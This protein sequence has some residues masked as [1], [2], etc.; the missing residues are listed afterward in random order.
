MLDIQA[1]QRFGLFAHLLPV[2]SYFDFSL[3]LL[4]PQ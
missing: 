2:E 3:L 1:F 4:P